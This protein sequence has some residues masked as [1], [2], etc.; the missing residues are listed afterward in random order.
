MK[1]MPCIILI[2]IKNS[3]EIDDYI[4]MKTLSQ[5]INSANV[6]YIHGLGSNKSSSTYISLKK[7]F[8]EYNI[9]TD[10]FDLLNPKK[11]NKQINDIIKKYGITKV[12]GSS[13]GGFYTLC[14]NDTLGKIVINPCMDPCKEVPKLVNVPENTIKEW[15]NMMKKTY[16]SID[17]E[18]RMSVFGLFGTEDELFSYYDKWVD[19]YGTKNAIKF[20]SKHR[21]TESQLNWVHKGFE[22]LSNTNNYLNENYITEH[23]VN[24]FVTQ[25]D[26]IELYKNDVYNLLVNAYEPIGGLKGIDSVDQLIRDTSFWKLCTKN[27][28][29]V[30]AC[31]Y[32]NKRGGRKLIACG[33]DGSETGKLWLYKIIQEDIKFKD[34]KSWAEVSD[35]LEHIFIKKNN[36]VPIPAELAQKIMKN[37]P[38]Y[39]IHDD[40][41]HYDR[42]IGGEIHTKIMVGY[43]E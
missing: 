14:C 40:G 36:A 5:Y 43:P 8:P 22:Y 16:S 42:M 30:A 26:K 41:Y 27:N 6:L 23:F 3:G 21:P 12:I 34:R 13:L 7:L 24:I 20:P 15:S 25:D 4:H 35:K 33:T 1:Y 31:V 38:F 18:I 2:F 9:Y 28:K 29:I 11:A 17:S 10:T 39:K 19:L 32:S 37:K